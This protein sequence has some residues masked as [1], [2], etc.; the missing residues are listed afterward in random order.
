MIGT[1]GVDEGFNPKVTNESSSPSA[2]S[3]A[4]AV[5]PLQIQIRLN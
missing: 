3:A 5:Y 1:V 4:E 2:Q